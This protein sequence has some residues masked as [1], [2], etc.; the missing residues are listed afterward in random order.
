MSVAW[1]CEICGGSP[2]RHIASGSYLYYR[3]DQCGSFHVQPQPS[4]DALRTY[5]EAYHE[6]QKEHDGGCVFGERT[7]A[8]FPAK[9][10]Y[11]KRMTVAQGG[12]MRL[13]DV[14]CGKGWFLWEAM[15]AGFAVQGVDLSQAAV[16]FARDELGI[17]VRHGSLPDVTEQAWE[18]RF[19]VIT[20]WAT[21]EHVADPRTTLSAAFRCLRPGGHLFLDTGLGDAW[22]DR[23]LPGHTQWFDAPQHLWVF[24]RK[25]LSLLLAEAG[26]EVRYVDQNWERSFTRRYL[27]TIR[28]AGVS[29]LAYATLRP[30]LGRK[31]FSHM[32]EATRWPIGMLISVVARKPLQ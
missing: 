9:V 31:A 15:Q 18:D 23:F 27:K 1:S 24:S 29:L 28:V 8:D 12:E 32:R 4:D 5:Y 19:D 11:V 30:F 22:T 21:I 13:M 25:G 16:E 7:R 2:H 20:L 17:S 6:F 10:R 26:F 14:G 3:C